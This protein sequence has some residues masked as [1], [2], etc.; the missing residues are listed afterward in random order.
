MLCR[1]SVG[2]S[3]KGYSL[4]QCLAIVKNKCLIARS[5]ISP[6]LYSSEGKSSSQMEDSDNFSLFF[7]F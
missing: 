6:Y 2:M 5:V 1:V 3:H 4:A 7:H